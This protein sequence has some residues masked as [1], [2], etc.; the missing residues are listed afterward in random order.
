MKCSTI[1]GNDNILTLE[2]LLS[3][4]C[5]SF[6]TK[7]RAVFNRLSK[8]MDRTRVISTK[9]DE[10]LSAGNDDSF[11]IFDVE[12]VRL[13]FKKWTEEIP[14]VVPYYAIK[15][16]D[17]PEIAKTLAELG[18][19][20]DCASIKE[21]DQILSMGIDQSRIIYSHTVKQA[22]H[23][24]FAADN[25]VEMVTFDCPAELVKIKNI[26]PNAKVV[27]RIKFDAESSIICMGIKFGCDPVT[28]APELIKQCKESGMNLIGISFHV[29]SGTLDYKIYERA[30]HSVRQLFDLAVEFG[31]KLNFVDI[32]GG[33]M[34]NDINL[35]DNYA[36]FINQG[37]DQYF[38]DPSV[39]IIS[40]PGRYFSESAFT[41]VAQVI[42]KKFTSDGHVHYYINDSI[43]QSFIIAFIYEAN[44]Q[45]KI[46]RKTKPLSDPIEHP[47]TIWGQTCNSK[48][49][50]L[51]NRLIPE[52][53]IGDYLAFENMG[54]YTTTV[55]SHFNGFKIGEVININSRVDS[56]L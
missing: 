4:K 2:T 12:D 3:Q 18:A 15:C 51:E 55:S 56:L 50:I 41:L 25:G 6:F 5:S 31:F 14:R 27:L 1:F 44:L 43:Y 17:E 23:L 33:F 32:G 20:F 36:K 49:K 53:E 30:L 47:S 52:L 54:A 38:P 16:N 37:I 45:F 24:K 48:D 46:I 10:R 26:H 9:I 40:E 28:E 29:G 35:L 42:L 19:G 34:G 7:I 8:A 21:I 11:Y 39:T 22:S 13:K